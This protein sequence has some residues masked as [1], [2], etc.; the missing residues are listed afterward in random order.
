VG[1]RTI[2]VTSLPASTGIVDLTVYQ[3][4]PPCGAALLSRGARVSA[5][6]TVRGTAAR[7]LVARVSVG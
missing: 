6:A 2:V 1:G 3:P 5:V 7:R 4:R